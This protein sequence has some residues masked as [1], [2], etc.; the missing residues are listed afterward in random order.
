MIVSGEGFA[1][2]QQREQ[3]HLHNLLP[4]KKFQQD[5]DPLP[6]GQHL[7]HGCA[8]AAER[9]VSQLHFLPLGEAGA[10][11]QHFFRS[12]A[13]DLLPQD[14]HEIVR[15]GRHLVPEADE[16]A[17]SLA[18][19]DRPLPRLE[20]EAGEHIAGKE[21]LHPPHLPATGGLPVPQHR[22]K[23]FHLLQFPQM[24]RGD[25]LPLGLRLQAVP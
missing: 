13:A 6:G 14:F 19:H 25:G 23:N 12:F 9:S 7:H 16:P 5:F 18:V 21:S 11:C 17:D 10:D 22:A 3:V 20:R 8:H 24:S 4:T 1:R 15:D 2:E